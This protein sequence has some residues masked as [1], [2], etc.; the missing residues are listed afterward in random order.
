M[1]YTKEQILLT[2]SLIIH[3]LCFRLQRP[4]RQQDLASCQ[5]FLG[6]D[7]KPYNFEASITINK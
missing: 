2:K 5:S 1:V 7:L 6:E 4:S 3:T